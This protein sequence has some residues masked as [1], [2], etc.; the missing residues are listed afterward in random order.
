MSVGSTKDGRFYVQY[1]VPHS[2]SPKREYF[3]RGIE[4]RKAAKERDAEVKLMKA[5]Q[6]DVRESDV[7]LDEL[8]QTY[9]DHE[10]AI[11]KKSIKDLTELANRLNRSY[12][13]VLNHA[14]IH[15]LKARDFD[16]LALEYKGLSNCSFNRYLA[17]LNVIFNF[18]MD[19]D[20]IEKNPMANWWKRVK[21]QEKPRELEIGREEI[22][23]ISDNAPPHIQ[24]VIKIIMNTGCRPG[25]TE[26]LKIKY[27]DVDYEN[28][29]IRIRGTKTIRSDRYVPVQNEFLE[30]IK[31]WEKEAR[32]EHLVEFRGKPIKCINGAFLKSVKRAGIT[33]DVV[34]YHLRHYFASILVARKVDFKTLSV[35][36]GHSSPAMLFST[37]CHSVDGTGRKAIE[38]LPR[39]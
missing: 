26:L 14:P 17:Y 22:Q 28:K 4:A 32:T 36:M 2:K 34:P 29:V 25:Q 7:Y 16:K 3:G 19:S 23:A 18:G 38:K 21:K 13:P 24:R 30:V 27:S 35:L 20:Y 11:G 10:K 12:L 9:I 8:A 31:E 37:Y 33:K 5:R 39:F 1:R 15:K 6:E